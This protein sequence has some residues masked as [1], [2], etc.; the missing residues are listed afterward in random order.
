MI[1]IKSKE[2]IN[3]IRLSG[4]ILA[5]TMEVLRNKVKVGITTKEIDCWAEELISKE[6][7]LPAFKGYKGYP[8]SVCTSVNEEVVHG[9]PSERRL[10]D[11][12]LLSIDLGVN[13]KG[14][15]SDCAITVGIGKVTGERKKLIEVAKRALQL[16]IKQAKPE[17]HL[18]DISSAIQSYVESEGFSVVRQFVGHGTGLAIHEDPEIPN[19]GL[20]HK[21]PVLRPGM[22]LAIEPMV[23]MGGWE[24]EILQDGWTAV[25]RDRQPSSHFEH[26][27]AVGENGPEIL[28]KY[29]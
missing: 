7:A 11:G 6:G 25:T 14:Y 9:I 21:G 19:F 15:F 22:V 27:V 4:E 1:K 16:G 29:A 23:N 26:T 10:K 8:A 17:N 18:S 2:E 28:T 5:R 20:P 24:V 12:D 3:M 13:Y